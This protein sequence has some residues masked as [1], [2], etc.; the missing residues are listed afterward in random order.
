MTP[1]PSDRESARHR[2]KRSRQWEH[3]IEV[4]TC[5][6]GAER[7]NLCTPKP[8]T[9][10]FGQRLKVLATEAPPSQAI[11]PKGTLARSDS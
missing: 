6:D 11:R 1:D 7:T 9:L 3:P 2:S 5:R 8:L 10:R 4:T